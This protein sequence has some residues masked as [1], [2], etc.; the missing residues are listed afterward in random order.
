M[1][2]QSLKSIA[3]PV[4]L[5]V[6][7]HFHQLSSY[8]MSLTTQLNIQVI[9]TKYEYYLFLMEYVFNKHISVSVLGLGLG[10]PLPLTKQCSEN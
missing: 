5:V 9:Q 10:F 2:I 8:V 7:T 3:L 1:I 4:N 6:P